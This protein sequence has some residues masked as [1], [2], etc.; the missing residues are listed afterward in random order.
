ATSGCIAGESSNGIGIKGL[1]DD[2]CRLS[3][4]DVTVEPTLGGIIA[5]AQRGDIIVVNVSTAVSVA[6]GRTLQV[7]GSHTRSL[8]D[9]IYECV[10]EIGAVVVL[11][12]GNGYTD[13][14]EGAQLDLI[15]EF[16]DW[17]DNGSSMISACVST[18][19]N[20]SSFS[21]SGSH[22]YM[23][24]WGD[25]VVTTGYGDL[26]TVVGTDT[27][28]YTAI[29]NGTSSATPLVGGALTL[30]QG[31][32][33]SLLGVVLDSYDMRELMRL[34]GNSNPTEIVSGRR[35]NVTVALQHLIDTTWG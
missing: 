14:W 29:Y 8:W 31:Y 32:S 34:T 4:Y 35:P 17:G 7:P 23:N 27:R 24:S 13:R 3:F 9:Q 25:S 33:R 28:D 26:H 30:T 19:G 6:S 2:R 11:A 22:V 20:L 15:P 1:V 12:A 21:N 5:D 16:N 10:N 18:S